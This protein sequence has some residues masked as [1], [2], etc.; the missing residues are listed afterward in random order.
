MTSN[1]KPRRSRKASAIIAATAVFGVATVATLATWTVTEYVNASF[2]TAPAPQGSIEGS[3]NGVDFSA[4]HTTATAATLNWNVNTQSLVV[5]E[6]SQVVF[7][8][9]YL[10]TTVGTTESVRFSVTA[11]WTGTGNTL[12]PSLSN[13]IYLLDSTETSCS[14]SMTAATQGV[15]EI[16]WSSG[17]PGSYALPSATASAPGAVKKLCIATTVAANAPLDAPATM[18]WSFTAEDH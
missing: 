5:G 15:T 2:R 11:V 4:H 3:A 17:V 9:Y 7:A 8:P 16:T 14:A 1:R 6:T 10:R 12:S 18:R 13:K